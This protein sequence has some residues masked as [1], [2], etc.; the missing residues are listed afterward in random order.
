MHSGSVCV[1]HS[2]LRYSKSTVVIRAKPKRRKEYICKLGV[3]DS[4]LPQKRTSLDRGHIPIFVNICRHEKKHVRFLFMVSEIYSCLSNKRDTYGE[5]A[6]T[7]LGLSVDIPHF[8][9]FDATLCNRWPTMGWCLQWL[10]SGWVNYKHDST[11]TQ[12]VLS[13][14]SVRKESFVPKVKSRFSGLLTTTSHF[15][16]ACST[17]SF[18]TPLYSRNRRWQVRSL[19]S[20]FVYGQS[21]LQFVVWE[22]HPL[23]PSCSFCRQNSLRTFAA[24]LRISKDS[25]LLMLARGLPW[26]RK[27]PRPSVSMRYFDCAQILL[28]LTLWSGWASSHVHTIN[29]AKCPSWCRHA[30][31][32]FRYDNR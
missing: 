8:Q 26:L 1:A 16:R 14:I 32:F 28:T 11:V 24:L 23:S 13:G 21:L 10:C 31:P 5:K 30:G 19:I 22:K 18:H 20:A 17:S 27:P 3:A 9:P 2:H 12:I 29:G 25:K 6:V 7:Q 15:V 4:A